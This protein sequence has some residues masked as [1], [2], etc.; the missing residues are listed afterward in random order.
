MKIIEI[1]LIRPSR[2][3]P[4]HIKFIF[5]RHTTVLKSY[6][7]YFVKLWNISYIKFSR[8]FM[9]QFRR[10]VKIYIRLFLYGTQNTYEKDKKYCGQRRITPYKILEQNIFLE[11]YISR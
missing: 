6:G 10:N 8:S 3:A 9:Y 1:I 7:E 11:K 4:V 2:N 5:N